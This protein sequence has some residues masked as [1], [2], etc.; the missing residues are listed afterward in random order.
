MLTRQAELDSMRFGHGL[1]ALKAKQ[2]EQSLETIQKRLRPILD[3]RAPV[4][5]ERAKS[6]L[7]QSKRE[8]DESRRQGRPER[9]ARPWGFSIPPCDPLRFKPTQVDGLKLRVDL[10][11]KAFWNADPAEK[12]AQLGV[13]LRVWCLDP[14]IYFREEWDSSE[15]SDAT[16]PKIGRVMLRVHFDLANP[17]Q[18]GPEY[19]VQVGGRSRPEEHHW[20]PQSLAVPRLLHIP[21]DLTLASEL[22]AAT[23]YQNAFKNIRR[24]DSWRGSRRVS[25]EHLLDEYFADALDAVRKNKSVLETLWNVSWDV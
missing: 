16:D 6:M 3:D 9:P 11:S 19:H 7:R 24:E 12:P 4:V 15:L 14:Q 22:V 25:Q 1:M 23:F 2:V 13:L 8:W 5:V 18:P 21:V 17:K 20:F 10:S